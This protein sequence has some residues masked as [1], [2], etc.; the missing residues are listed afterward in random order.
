MSVSTRLLQINRFRVREYVIF[1]FFLVA[2]GMWDLD[3]LIRDPTHIYQPAW[4]F[5]NCTAGEV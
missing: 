2:H 3:F 1:F 5:N 4:S